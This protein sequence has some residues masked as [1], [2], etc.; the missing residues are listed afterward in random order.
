VYVPVCGKTKISTGQEKAA[1][2]DFAVHLLPF[3]FLTREAVSAHVRLPIVDV[4]EAT[5]VMQAPIPFCEARVEEPVAGDLKAPSF[6]EL[7]KVGVC[8][9]C[10]FALTFG[11]HEEVL[12]VLAQGP[13]QE[14]GCLRTKSD[15]N[16]T[17]S[18]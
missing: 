17:P 8:Q 18:D 9:S 12:F 14:A 1:Y 16:R 5:A 13:R 3:F 2:H 6:L 7:E 15:G 4:H 10:V 11:S